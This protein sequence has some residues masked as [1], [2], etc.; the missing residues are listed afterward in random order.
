MLTRLGIQRAQTHLSGMFILARSHLWGAPELQSHLME[1]YGRNG[2]PAFS[3][4]FLSHK[5]PVLWQDAKERYLEPR[6]VVWPSA[7]G[8]RL[9]V[10][11]VVSGVQVQASPSTILNMTVVFPAKAI[12]VEMNLGCW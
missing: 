11:C 12:W 7:G 9:A 2:E 4:V 5:Q 8:T 6:S 3:P 1:I 10:T